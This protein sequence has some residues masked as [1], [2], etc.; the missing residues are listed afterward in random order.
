VQH[1]WKQDAIPVTSAFAEV[2]NQELRKITP[3]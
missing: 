1:A 2:V 3:P